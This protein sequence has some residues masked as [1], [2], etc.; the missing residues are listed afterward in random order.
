MV[1]KPNSL[2]LA[3]CAV[4]VVAAAYRVGFAEGRDAGSRDAP[5]YNAVLAEREAH[6]RLWDEALLADMAPSDLERTCDQVVEVVR[7]YLERDFALDQEM[8]RGSPQE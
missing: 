1:L 2:I 8:M 4:A 7:D 3:A 5:S 6:A